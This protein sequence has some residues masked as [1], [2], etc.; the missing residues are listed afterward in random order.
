[1]KYMGSKTKVARYIVPI[2]QDQIDRSGFET[3]RTKAAETSRPSARI[4]RT[5][6]FYIRT[7]GHGAQSGA[8]YIWIHPTR[9]RSNTN[10]LKHSTTQTSGELQGSGVTKTLYS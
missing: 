5:S 1:M 6:Y 4:W 10:R 9:T 7:T 2:I 8:S 3:I